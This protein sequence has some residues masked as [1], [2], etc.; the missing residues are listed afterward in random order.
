MTGIT[1]GDVNILRLLRPTEHLYSEGT[2]FN[3]DYQET[4]KLMSDLI[5][6]SL[7]HNED[8]YLHITPLTVI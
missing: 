7:S 3:A 4:R 2:M 5:T 8:M 1:N 6:V